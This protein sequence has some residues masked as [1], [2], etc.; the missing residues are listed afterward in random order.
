[1]SKLI[2]VA[3]FTADV[4]LAAEFYQQLL[5]RPPVRRVEGMVEF[6]LGDVILRIHDKNRVC[7]SDAPAED[8]IAIAV[9]NLE[10]AS[11]TSE[12]NGLHCE[13]PPHSYE[14][15]RSAYFRDPDGRLLELHEQQLA[16]ETAQPINLS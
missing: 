15:G 8:H 9:D 13:V 4:E 6:S 16:S 14:W 7:G 11:S 12:Q 1:M 3:R 5:A 10:S 2:E